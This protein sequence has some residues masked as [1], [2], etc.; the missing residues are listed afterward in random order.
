[1]QR[2]LVV[3]VAL[4]INVS[5]TM[6]FRRCVSVCRWRVVDTSLLTHNHS[7]GAV[8]E[9]EPVLCSTARLKAFLFAV[10]ESVHAKG[11]NGVPMVAGGGRER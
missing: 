7:E 6:G 11:F 10:S 4:K 9:E 2:L 5:L 1:M 3:K 8:K